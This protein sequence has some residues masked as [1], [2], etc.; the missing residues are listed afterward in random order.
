MSAHREMIVVQPALEPAPRLLVAVGSVAW[1][2]YIRWSSWG[3]GFE[4][5]SA[6]AAVQIGPLMFGG[7][8][9]QRQIDAG[10]AA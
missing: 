9:I 5:L 3:V 2:L 6:G 10:D 8:H 4:I 7:C 1:F